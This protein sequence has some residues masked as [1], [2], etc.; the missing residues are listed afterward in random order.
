V[1]IEDLLVTISG[2]VDQEKD[3]ERK[4]EERRPHVENLLKCVCESFEKTFIPL[5][6]RDAQGA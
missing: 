1:Q 3:R 4:L 5:T 6:R 2:V